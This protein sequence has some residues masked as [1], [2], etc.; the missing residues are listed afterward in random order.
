MILYR[1]RYCGQRGGVHYANLPIHNNRT[2]LYFTRTVRGLYLY[3][4]IGLARRVEGGVVIDSEG[5][6]MLVMK[7]TTLAPVVTQE[8]IG[9][10][11]QTRVR[12]VGLGNVL[13]G[14][15]EEPRRAIEYPSTSS[16]PSTSA[17]PGASSS[18][19]PP[20]RRNPAS[21]ESSCCVLL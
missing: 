15:Q 16:C 11:V 21:T 12:G 19:N 20:P 10:A 8:G 2:V 18:T 7:E 5:N 6:A 4:E 9:L 14:Q 17:R 1:N 3:R 13:S